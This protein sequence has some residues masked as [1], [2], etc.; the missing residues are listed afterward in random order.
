MAPELVAAFNVTVAK[1]YLTLYM[2]VGVLGLALFLRLLHRR[3]LLVDHLVFGLHVAM[4]LY[5]W[6]LLVRLLPVVQDTATVVALLTAAGQVSYI[7]IAYMRVYGGRG[8]KGRSLAFLGGV[9]AN[10]ALAVPYGLTAQASAVWML[11]PPAA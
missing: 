4:F 5:L 10:L 7:I 9:A 1:R 11:M 8:W 6:N 3:V 2:L